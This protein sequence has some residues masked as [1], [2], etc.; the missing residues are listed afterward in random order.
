LAEVKGIKLTNIEDFKNSIIRKRNRGVSDKS[1]VREITEKNFRRKYS[2]S[3]A[4]LLA[5]TFTKDEIPLYLIKFFQNY[6]L[7]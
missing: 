6:I 5:K 7:N 1:I 4:E 2:S 3:F